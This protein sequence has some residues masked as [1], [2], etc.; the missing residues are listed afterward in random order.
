MN[1]LFTAGCGLAAFTALTIGYVAHVVSSGVP[2]KSLEGD[3]FGQRVGIYNLTSLDE[4]IPL[5]SG[6]CSPSQEQDSPYR[7]ILYQVRLVAIEMSATAPFDKDL[8]TGECLSHIVNLPRAL[9]T[10]L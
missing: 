2:Y 3:W 7:A 6:G 4:P 1:R 10:R 8:E 9:K 5:L